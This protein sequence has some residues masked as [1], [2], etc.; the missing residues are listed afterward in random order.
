[1]SSEYD[2]IG[3]NCY[4]QWSQQI[5]NDLQK[6]HQHQPMFQQNLQ[7]QIFSTLAINC[8]LL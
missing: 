6:K 3:E 5:L 1:M 2:E 8:D 4:F 7:F